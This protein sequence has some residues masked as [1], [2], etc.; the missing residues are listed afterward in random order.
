[1]NQPCGRRIKAADLCSGENNKFLVTSEDIIDVREAKNPARLPRVERSPLQL[2]CAAKVMQCSSMRYW[3]LGASVKKPR[4]K[5]SDWTVHVEEETEEWTYFTEES[6]EEILIA[7]P[8]DVITREK[9]SVCTFTPIFLNNYILTPPNND[10][11]IDGSSFYDKDTVR[12]M[13]V[14]LGTTSA[15][16]AFH[17]PHT[18]CVKAWNEIVKDPQ[19]GAYYRYVNAPLQH[20]MKTFIGTS[21]QHEEIVSTATVSA[22]IYPDV[23]I[24]RR[25]VAQ[26]HQAIKN[27]LAKFGVDLSCGL[28]EVT[29]QLHAFVET[30]PEVSVSTI[31]QELTL[32]LQEC[33]RDGR[34]YFDKKYTHVADTMVTNCTLRYYFNCIKSPVLFPWEDAFWN[35][36]PQAMIR[37]CHSGLAELSCFDI[38]QKYL[39][40]PIDDPTRNYIQPNPYLTNDVGREPPKRISFPF[41]I[42]AL[43]ALLSKS[44][45]IAS[46]PNVQKQLQNTISSCS[47]LNTYT[48]VLMHGGLNVTAIQVW[49]GCCLI[50]QQLVPYQRGK[51]VPQ[52]LNC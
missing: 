38:S 50:L 29:R 13:P 18:L 31:G 4:R 44:N 9:P 46:D 41:S 20:L 21:G 27:G 47:E 25:V 48:G 17:D 15:S 14:S 28:S 12:L 37:T 3:D 16:K 1:M 40:L 49:V 33:A 11:F 10:P 24:Y 7:S 8:N 6:E 35:D 26:K 51:T 2:D 32:L 36:D 30:N 34:P 39:P 5:G 43:E 19:G 23:R 52:P 22:V 45:T 42:T